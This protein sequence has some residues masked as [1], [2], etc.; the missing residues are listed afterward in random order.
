[1]NQVSVLVLVVV[2][3]V[4]VVFFFL[5]KLNLITV[6]SVVFD[7]RDYTFIQICLHY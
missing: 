1:M 6:Q 7:K 3:V 2:V 4:V 5:Q